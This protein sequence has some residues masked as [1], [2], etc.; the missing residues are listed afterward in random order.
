MGRINQADFEGET[1]QY[2]GGGPAL[3]S[4]VIEDNLGIPTQD[5]VRIRQEGLV[6]LVDA[7]GGVTITLDCPLHELTPH[8]SL[9]GQFQKFDLPAG[10]VFLNGEDAKKF[11]TFRYNSNDFYRGKRQQQ[12]IWAIRNRALQLNAIPK[13]PELWSAAG[14]DIQDRSERAGYCAPGA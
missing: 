11:A 3:L 13:I 10:E 8:P 5:W 9:E 4:K 12:L 14:P 1:N 7:L 2:P 6:Q